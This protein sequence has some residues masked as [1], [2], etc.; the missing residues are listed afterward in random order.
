MQQEIS[1]KPY[2]WCSIK[3]MNAVCCK[4]ISTIRSEVEK[5]KKIDRMNNVPSHPFLPTA[6]P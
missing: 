1:K 5:G 2:E 4:T 3:I 6:S